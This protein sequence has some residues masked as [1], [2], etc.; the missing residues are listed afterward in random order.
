MAPSPVSPYRLRRKSLYPGMLGTS[1][2]VVSTTTDQDTQMSRAAP[3]LGWGVER[4]DDELNSIEL[5]EVGRR[6]TVHLV[7]RYLSE[8][9][10][11]LRTGRSGFTRPPP[12]HNGRPARRNILAVNGAHISS[13]RYPLSSSVLNLGLAHPDT[14]GPSHPTRVHQQHWHYSLSL[15]S[16]GSSQCRPKVSQLPQLPQHPLFLVTACVL[17]PLPP[18]SLIAPSQLQ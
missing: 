1:A 12:T 5:Q 10:R 18:P 9:S 3:S 4:L 6:I 17:I 2:H 15:S 16:V 8:N 11:E 13:L 14:A 7:H